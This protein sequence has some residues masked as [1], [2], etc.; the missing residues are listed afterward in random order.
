M[1]LVSRLSSTPRSLSQSVRRHLGSCAVLALMSLGTGAASAQEGLGVNALE[2]SW[3]RWSPRLTP[4]TDARGQVQSVGLVGDYLFTPQKAGMAEGLRATGG[5]VWGTGSSRMVSSQEPSRATLLNG[6][7]RFGS[8][9][10]N[11]SMASEG[12]S[13]AYFGLGYTR[14]NLRAGWRVNADIGVAWRLAPGTVKLGATDT[15]AP[16]EDV[17]RDARLAPLMHLSVSY[18]F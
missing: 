9:N 3:G 16:L 8:Q 2:G 15:S 13:A 17:L 6:Q 14:A 7:P 12:R 1:G 10:S 11:A 4:Q 5:L 18:S